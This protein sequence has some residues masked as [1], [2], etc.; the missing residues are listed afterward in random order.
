MMSKMAVRVGQLGCRGLTNTI[1]HESSHAT[2]LRINAIT[3]S[4]LSPIRSKSNVASTSSSSSTPAPL[5]ATIFG[6]HDIFAPR[7]LGPSWPED[8]TKMLSVIGY[9]T[10]DAL[11]DATI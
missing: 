7:H 8:V 3:S 1:R 10:L 4:Q 6:P 11:I 9:N 5:S 2:K